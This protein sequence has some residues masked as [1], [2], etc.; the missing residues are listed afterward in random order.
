MYL[1]SPGALQAGAPTSLTLLPTTVE[2]A[3][4]GPE[5]T[6]A[7]GPYWVS[8]MRATSNVGE[9]WLHLLL[10][11]ALHYPLDPTSDEQAH[12]CSLHALFSTR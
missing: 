2:Q 5:V 3:I 4:W 8:A 6:S 11:Q 7:L 9:L 1:R 10:R 12:N